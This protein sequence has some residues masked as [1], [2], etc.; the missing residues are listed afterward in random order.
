MGG[1]QS[2]KNIKTVVRTD[3]NQLGSVSSSAGP[4]ADGRLKPEITALGIIESTNGS[5]GGYFGSFGTSMSSPGV[6]GRLALLYQRYRQLDGGAYPMG[7]TMKALLLNGAMDIGTPGPDY[8][9]GYGYMNLERSLRMLEASQYSQR[10]INHGQ[11]QDTV[12]NVPSGTAQ[13]KVMLY[14][15]DPAALPF[16]SKT[17]VHNLDLEV[18][19]PGGGVNRPLILQA[20]PANV[21]QPATLGGDAVNNSEQ[22]V[23][24]APVPGNYT[25]RVKGTDVLAGGSQRYALAFDKQPA[26]LRFLNPVANDAWPSGTVGFPGGI[27][28]VWEDEGNPTGTY[29]LDYSLDDGS[30]WTNIFTGLA[31]SMRNYFWIPG[32]IRSP[33]TRLRLAKTGVAQP[34]I[35]GRFALI[36][37]VSFSLAANIDQCQGY[38]RINWTALTAGP[39]ETI[40]Y[41]V[42]MKQGPA[43]EVVATTTANTYTLAGLHPDSTYYIAVRARINGVHGIYERTVNRRPNTGNCSGNISDFDLRLDSITAPL[44]GRQFTST[45]LG[46]QPVQVRVRNLDNTPVNSY[47]IEVWVNGT[48]LGGPQVINTPIIETGIANHSI[49]SFNFSNPGTYN[50]MAVVKNLQNPDPVAQNDTFRTTIRQLANSP[51]TL[52]SP[53]T[54]DLEDAADQ[55]AIR[56]ATGVA[57]TQRWDFTSTDQYGRARTSATPGVARSGQRA[58]TLDVSKATPL[59]TSAANSLVGTFNL[60]GAST[61]QPVRLDFYYKQHGIGQGP[62]PQN[63]VW[64]RG[65]DAA[66]WLEVYDLALNQPVEPG[67]YKQSASLPIAQVLAANGQAFST[68]TQIRL[69]QFGLYSMADEK[70]LSGYSF[71]D[72][73]LYLAENDAQ[74]LAI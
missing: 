49:G 64:V 72:F 42:L 25:L 39:G 4:V 12:I 37:N 30:T 35:S 27:P 40:D 56:G 26:E 38:A 11:V 59:A 1:Y 62:H 50:L 13:L 54:D 32:N 69:G 17:L 33:Q 71:D 23:I 47:S 61:S 68:S 19:A 66:T 51:I 70:N 6:A 57:N 73:K 43:M 41:Q 29:T 22:V 14:W 60:S 10:T 21:Q 55:T 36:P 65:N 46:T 52:T 67:E 18:I 31:D 2:A 53:F 28:L 63:K 8:K 45:A 5:G 15:H 48:S 44:T 24:A 16:A 58:F 34:A 74:L 20:G 7:H 3:Y 9:H